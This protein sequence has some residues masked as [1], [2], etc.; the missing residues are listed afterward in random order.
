M[1]DTRLNSS[2]GRAW[3]AGALALCAFLAFTTGLATRGHAQSAAVLFKNARVFDGENVR[4]NTDVLVRGTRIVA[5]GPGLSAPAGTQTIDATGKTLLPGL[6]DAH[7]HAFGDALREALVLGVTT[8]LDMFTDAQ[9]ARALRAQQK[10]GNV[11]GRAD[12]FSASTLVTA[13]QGHGTQFGITIPTITSADSAQAFV[14]ARVA[15][16]SD[17]IKLVYDDGEVYGLKFATL[18]R[19]TMRAVIAAAHRRS[20]LAV[21]HVGS[22]A[23]ARD[24]IEAGADGLVHLFTDT[25]AAPNFA[26]LAKSK[27][28]FVIPTLVVLKGV[29]GEPGAAGLL[30]DARIAP[31]VTATAR[32]GLRQS[33]PVRN[34]AR[35][36]SYDVA[37]QTV[38]ALLQAGVRVLA[39]S[40]APNPGTSHGAA[41]HRELELLVQAGLTPVQALAAATS[42]SARAFRL[43]DRGRIAAGLRADLLLVNGDPTVDI[44]ATRAIE[45]VWKGGVQLDRAAF[46]QTVAAVPTASATKAAAPGLIA[47]FESGQPSAQYGTAWVVNTDTY[48]GGQ[49][50]G[51]VTMATD[52][53]EGSRGS[54]LITGTISNAL[55]YA[56]SG[57]MWSPGNQ[58]MAPADLSATK[59]LRFWTKGDG[60][61]YRVI[62][63]AQSKGM[64]PLMQDF[65]AGAEWREVV[66]PWSAFGIDAKDLMGVIVAGGP[67]PGA[68]RFQIDNV[69]TR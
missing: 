22:A 27:N 7:T 37:A 49:S 60:Q 24:A 39:G 25:L 10:E 29:S 8:E 17:Y 34:P 41:I 38:K 9:A 40:D 36:P 26:A 55:A 20:K 11:A 4:A 18:S 16:G 69:S 15:E 21:V 2:R 1:S 46:A 57:A 64:T 6:I 53:A 42:V 51:D 59:E 54:L 63:F 61:T 68:F 13:P 47:D 30:D 67:K 52:G 48:A 3:L 62:L 45:S 32:A 43:N 44:T 56:W 35:R 23:G 31:Y 33:F 19:E 50:T 28:V 12:L 66:M 65:V 58:P 5:I 14:D